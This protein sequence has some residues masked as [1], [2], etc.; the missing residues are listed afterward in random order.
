MDLFLLGLKWPLCCWTARIYDLQVV[1]AV[2]GPVTNTTI[3]LIYE[4]PNTSIPN[5]IAELN[6]HTWASDE[7]CIVKFECKKMLTDL[8]HNEEFC[9]SMRISSSHEQTWYPEMENNQMLFMNLH[10]I[11]WIKQI[12][13]ILSSFHLYVTMQV[14]IIFQWLYFPL[15]YL[16]WKKWLFYLRNDQLAPRYFDAR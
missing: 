5:F 8:L 4:Y 12:N 11:K 6:T 14:V 9:L 7:Y 3:T 15:L 1:A 10:F 13:L 16:L 2:L